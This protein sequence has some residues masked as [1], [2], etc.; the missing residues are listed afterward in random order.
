MDSTSSYSKNGLNINPNIEP[1][2]KSAG[3][4]IVAIVPVVLVFCIFSFIGIGVF[5]FGAYLFSSRSEVSE[6]NIIA[7]IGG[8]LFLSHY[9]SLEVMIK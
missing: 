5:S 3:S 4:S 7:N 6:S 1:K 2:K 9:V 8:G